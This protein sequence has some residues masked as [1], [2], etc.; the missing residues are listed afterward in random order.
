MQELERTREVELRHVGKEQ[1]SDV[2]CHAPIMPLLL[3]AAMTKIV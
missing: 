2:E 1:H 3:V